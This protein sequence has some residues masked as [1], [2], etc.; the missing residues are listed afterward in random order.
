MKT[1]QLPHVTASGPLVI[2]TA[3]VLASAIAF[4]YFAAPLTGVTGTPGAML[5]LIASLALALDGL[6]LRFRSDGAVFILAWVLGS[7]GALG[8]FIAAIGTLGSPYW[9]RC[10]L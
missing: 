2:V 4:Y 7:L 9:G 3:A 1:Y 6:L 5:V 8:T 10:T